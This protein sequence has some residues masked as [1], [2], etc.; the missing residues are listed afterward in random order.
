MDKRRAQAGPLQ[1]D[2]AHAVVAT[3]Q[4]Q[5]AGPR[6]QPLALLVVGRLDRLGVELHERVGVGGEA[7]AGGEQHALVVGRGLQ[8][9]F[10]R[11]QRERQR[12]TDELGVV[13]G[14]VHR[15]TRGRQRVAHRVDRHGLDR[16]RRQGQRGAGGQRH[17][18][19]RREAM[20]G[21]PTSSQDMTKPAG[22]RFRA[23]DPGLR[24]VT[25][26]RLL[27][28]AFEQ[29]V[30]AGGAVPQH[31]GGGDGGVVSS[32]LTIRRRTELQL[33]LEAALTSRPT[34]RRLSE[35]A[36]RSCATRSRPRGRG[37]QPKVAT[38]GPWSLDPISRCTTQVPAVRA[39]VSE[40]MT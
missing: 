4:V 2:A 38:T 32:V 33:R 8:Q 6:L 5:L 16:A 23:G 9:R 14:G 21:V 26:A 27:R 28:P 20:P 24:R 22:G 7:R 30:G 3:A 17:P 29:L 18:R 10:E 40:A 1:L 35:V 34:S 25:A 11:L 19:T 31:A 12:R 13:V 36:L 39:S 37:R 15:G